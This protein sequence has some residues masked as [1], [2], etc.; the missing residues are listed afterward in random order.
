MTAQ[1][2]R[3]KVLVAD[4]EAHIVQVVSLK[5]SNAGFDVQM[6]G[7]GEEAFELACQSLPALIITDLQMPYVSGLEL[8]VKLRQNP[9]TAGIPLIMLTARGYALAQSD[10]DRT[11]IKAVLSKPFSPRQILQRV[12]VLLGL[13]GEGEHDGH[14]EARAA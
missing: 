10:L 2:N 13:A 8:G 12:Q 6:A 14:E 9:A 11:N 4:D 7:D 3:I 5:L 1:P